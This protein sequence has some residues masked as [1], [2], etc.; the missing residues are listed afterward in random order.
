MKFNGGLELNHFFFRED[1]LDCPLV[2]RITVTDVKNER[3]CS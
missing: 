3:H 1:D 2:F